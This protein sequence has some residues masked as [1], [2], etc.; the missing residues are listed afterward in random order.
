[1]T[2]FDEA[3]SNTVIS[4]VRMVASSAATI[5]IGPNAGEFLYDTRLGI[6]LRSVSAGDSIL[7]TVQDADL[8][9]NIQSIQES[10]VTFFTSRNDQLATVRIYETGINSATFT[11]RLATRLV[12]EP[13]SGGVDMMDLVFGDRISAYYIDKAPDAVV[14]SSALVRIATPGTIELLP[15]A[16]VAGSDLNIV[17]YDQDLDRNA[18]LQEDAIVNLVSSRII[19]SLYPIRLTETAEGSGIFTAS[20]KTQDKTTVALAEYGVLNV[21]VNDEISVEYQDQSPSERYCF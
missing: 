20:I 1:V 17:L 3:P 21:L 12:E 4:T 6:K 11:G 19:A 8:N 14:K 13:L 15:T 2:Y 16:A 5:D 10:E 7:V 18:T 9:E